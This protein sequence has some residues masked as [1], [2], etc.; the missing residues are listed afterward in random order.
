MEWKDVG[1]AV[2]KFAPLLG[3]VLGG[4]VTGGAVSLICNAFGLGDDAQPQDVLQALTTNPE[5]ALKLRQ[6]ESDNQVELQRLILASEQAHLQD[7]QNARQREVDLAK[8]LGNREWTL[9]IL[10]W[11]NVAG[12][13]GMI[14]TVILAD[15]PDSEVAKSALLMLFGALVASYKDTIGYFFGTSK[16]SS[17]KT[18]LIARF[19]DSAD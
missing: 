4:P 15:L 10:A 14:V 11:I 18:K 19:K 1:N 8:A 17:D 2:K 13:F 9:Y 16:S 12:F 7:R 5:A 3:T 6:I